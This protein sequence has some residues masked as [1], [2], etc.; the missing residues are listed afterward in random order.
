MERILEITR[1]FS[2][3][4]ADDLALATQDRIKTSVDSIVAVRHAISHGRSVGISF[5]IISQYYGDAVK[6]VDLIE[7]QF[8]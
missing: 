1:F 6:L 5:S 4:W 8:G 2:S 3:Q 7:K